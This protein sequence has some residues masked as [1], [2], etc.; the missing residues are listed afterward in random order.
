[1]PFGRALGWS[2]RSFFIR[3]LFANATGTNAHQNERLADSPFANAHRRPGTPHTAPHDA[4]ACTAPGA[5]LPLGCDI[6]ASGPPP[7]LTLYHAPVTRP[8][9]TRAPFNFHRTASPAVQ[10]LLGGRR[11]LAV[12]S[13]PFSQNPEEICSSRRRASRRQ[14]ES[15]RQSASPIC[16]RAMALRRSTAR[17]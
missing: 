3:A 6:C 17:S 5:T 10:P 9:A 11:A 16:P 12:Q 14:R 8:D 15:V 1:M 4:P 7:R 2:G 13:P